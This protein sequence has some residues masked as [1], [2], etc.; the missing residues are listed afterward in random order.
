MGY[1]T[2]ED[3]IKY[4]NT[5]SIIYALFNRLNYKEEVFNG[6]LIYK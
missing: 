1:Y 6:M 5:N 3:T 4:I 2:D